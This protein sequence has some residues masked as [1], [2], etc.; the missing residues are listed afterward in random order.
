MKAEG[1]KL[2]QLFMQKDSLKIMY[3]MVLVNIFEMMEWFMKVN[4]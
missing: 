1:E 3:K 2:L 4:F